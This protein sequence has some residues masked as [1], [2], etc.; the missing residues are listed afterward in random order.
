MDAKASILARLFPDSLIV[1][2]PTRVKALVTAKQLVMQDQ[3]EYD[4]LWAEEVGPIEPLT[5]M[6]DETNGCLFSRGWQEACLGRVCPKPFLCPTQVCST[7]GY[8]VKTRNPG[9]TFHSSLNCWLPL[10]IRRSPKTR[11][12]QASITLGRSCACLASTS[13]AIR[14]N[15]AFFPSDDSA[16]WTLDG[17][18][19]RQE[20]EELLVLLL[21]D[22]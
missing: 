3:K 4:K 15:A 14:R 5:P 11:M 9:F 13:Q 12:V 21:F 8:P 7:S 10:S 19:Q 20:L 2:N 6:D 1:E 17:R 16:L 18:L 22:G